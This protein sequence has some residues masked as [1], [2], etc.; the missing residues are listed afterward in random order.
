MRLDRVETRYLDFS[1]GVLRGV[2]GGGDIKNV[3]PDTLERALEHIHRAAR[4]VDRLQRQAWREK[5]L[6]LRVVRGKKARRRVPTTQRRQ[7]KC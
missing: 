3:P 5:L 1:V 2:L 6:Q 7:K 4:V